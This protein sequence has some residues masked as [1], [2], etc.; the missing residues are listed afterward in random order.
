M[1][2][3]VN[4]PILD[5]GTGTPYLAIFNDTGMPIMNTLTGIPLGAY[6]SSFSYKTEESK[7]NLGT[8]NFSTGNPNTVDIS[9]IQEGKTII[10][11]WG[12][13]F[14]G[15]T[16]I[17]SKPYN[18]KIRDIDVSF[19]DSG[20][21]VTLKCVDA[22]NVIRQMPIYV[23]DPEQ[24]TTFLDFL[25]QGLGRGLGIIIEKFEFNG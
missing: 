13:I 14:S 4:K 18:L 8:L 10:I 17:S 9:E 23:P 7:E 2:K 11:Q 6:I 22:T 12:Y 15:G 21:K 5:R 16:S 3:L 24:E 19:D 25:N 20:T 1:E